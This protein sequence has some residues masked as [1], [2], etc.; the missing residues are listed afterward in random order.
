MSEL[1]RTVIRTVVLK[2]EAPGFVGIWNGD[3]KRTSIEHDR[4]YDEP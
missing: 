1:V 2:Q 3:I 4:I